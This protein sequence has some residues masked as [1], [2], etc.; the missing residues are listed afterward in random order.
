M[1]YPSIC[2]RCHQ[3]ILL[4]DREEEL[5]DD[6]RADVEKIV[7]RDE[8]MNVMS[9]HILLVIRRCP[10]CE[11]PIECAYNPWKPE[12]IYPWKESL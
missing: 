1:S 3:R 6:E 2:F 9:R 11:F 4:P 7:E 5:T 12:P 10:S 8:G